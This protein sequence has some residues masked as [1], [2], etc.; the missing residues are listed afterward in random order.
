MLSYNYRESFVYEKIKNKRHFKIGKM[1]LLQ[2][3]VLRQKPN[4]KPFPYAAAVQV[5]AL[6]TPQQIVSTFVPNGR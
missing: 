3:A 4:N 2:N 6:R 1:K 5:S